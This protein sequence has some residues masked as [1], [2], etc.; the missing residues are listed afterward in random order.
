VLLR[1][2]TSPDILSNITELLRIFDKNDDDD[3]Y[4]DAQICRARPK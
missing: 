2:C 1:Y 3:D 4:D